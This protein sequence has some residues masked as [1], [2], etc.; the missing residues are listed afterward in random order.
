MDNKSGKRTP[1]SGIGNSAR[2]N[3]KGY[4]GNNVK[5]RRQK[6]EGFFN[7]SFDY[8]DFLFLPKE[9]E[10]IFWGLYILIIPY[11]AG[12]LFLFLFVAEASYKYFL[13]FNLA[14]FFIIW[15]IGYEACAV[16]A[17]VGIF[18]GWLQYLS[19]RRNKEQVRKKS[20]R[21]RYGS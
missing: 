8:H 17:I 20:S 4:K 15:A 2:D 13:N 9:Y 19:S 1:S 14:S 18:L 5:T 16:L 7:K 10:G 11:L 6:E 3:V 12:L 21:D